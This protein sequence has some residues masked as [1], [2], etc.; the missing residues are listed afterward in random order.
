MLSS[1]SDV[2]RFQYL[3]QSGGY[4]LFGIAD[5]KMFLPSWVVKAHGKNASWLQGLAS[6]N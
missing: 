1:M 3:H 2:V 6:F 5:D 4:R